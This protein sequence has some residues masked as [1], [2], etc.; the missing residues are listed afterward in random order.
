MENILLPLIIL[1]GIAVLIIAV[2]FKQ[3][4]ENPVIKNQNDLEEWTC[5]EC[6]FSVQLGTEC[7]YC[8]TKKPG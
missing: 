7:P 3:W 6:G 1:T 5:P 8:Y 4:R 2:F